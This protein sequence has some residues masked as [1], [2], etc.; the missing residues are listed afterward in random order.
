MSDHRYLDSFRRPVKVALAKTCPY[1]Y[2]NPYPYPDQDI[3]RRRIVQNG[4]LATVEMKPDPE[5]AARE[6]KAEE[7][8]LAAA[9]AGMREADPHPSPIIVSPIPGPNPGPSPAKAGMSEANPDPSPLFFSPIPSPSPNPNPTKAGMSE[10]QLQAVIDA[11]ASL[12]AAQ[13]P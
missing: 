1:S 2:P 10:A 6:K 3:L 9:K 4:H 12:K 5:M 7:D 11:T 8:S 13:V